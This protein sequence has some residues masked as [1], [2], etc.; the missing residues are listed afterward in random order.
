MSNTSSPSAQSNSAIIWQDNKPVWNV[1]EITAYP[2]EIQGKNNTSTKVFVYMSPYE[3]EELKEI[4]RKVVSGYRREKKDLELEREDRSIYTPL[5]DAHF[6]KMDN[7]TGTPQ[8]QKAWLDRNAQWKPNFVEL[9]FGG[10]RKDNIAEETES[11]FDVLSDTVNEVTVYQDIYDPATGKTVRVDMTHSYR[12]PTEAQYREYRNAHRN[13][14]IQKRALWTVQENHNMLERLYDAV[15]QSISGVAVN[16]NP[17]KG[18]TSQWLSKIPLW[19]KLWVVD[20]IF[21]ELIE[22]NA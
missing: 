16:G 6:V 7:A 8:Q 5:C 11:A 13:K 4:L 9:T 17:C 2:L 18:D 19:H 14:L 3:P 20:N 12:T 10:L 22:K 1:T 15:I 21:T